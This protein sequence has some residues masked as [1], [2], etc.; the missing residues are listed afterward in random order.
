M[1]DPRNRMPGL[2]KL[3]LVLYFNIFTMLYMIFQTGWEPVLIQRIL[4]FFTSFSVKTLKRF[5]T[6]PAIYLRLKPTPKRSSRREKA[7]V[8]NRRKRRKNRRSSNNRLPQLPQQSP[9]QQEQLRQLQTRRA[10]MPRNPWRRRLPKRRRI[11]QRWRRTK[12]K[13][14][15]LPLCWHQRLYFFYKN[16]YC[17]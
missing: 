8:S 15:F 7:G 5:M 4:N 2:T 10:Q 1:L 17:T 16:K 12:R 6:K 11:N 14:W 3:V 13:R 9:L